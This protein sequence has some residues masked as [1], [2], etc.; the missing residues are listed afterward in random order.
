VIAV[1]PPDSRVPKKGSQTDSHLEMGTTKSGD[2]RTSRKPLQLDAGLA[3]AQ[4]ELRFVVGEDQGQH[5]EEGHIE[6]E[7]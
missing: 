3:F 7:D 2:G 6:Q 5:R 4:P 1:D